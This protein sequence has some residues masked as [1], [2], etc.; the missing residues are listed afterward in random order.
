MET[1]METKR[2]KNSMMKK[3]TLAIAILA[4]SLTQ[5][6]NAESTQLETDNT[7][8]YWGVGIGS[9]IGAV[10]AGPPGAALGATLGGSIGW[11]QDKDQAL[12]Q[13]LVELEKNEQVLGQ[14]QAALHQKQTT[15]LQ[16]KQALSELSRAN[17]Q[18]S[19]QLVNLKMQETGDDAQTNKTLQEVIGHY[20]QEVYFRNGESGVPIYA[21][22]RLNRLTE[23]LNSH[24]NLQVLLK[25]YTDQNGTAEFNTALAQARVDG[26]KEALLAKGVDASRV[27]TKAIGE[28]DSLLDSLLLTNESLADSSGDISDSGVSINDSSASVH[29]S[30]DYVL[31]RR[32]SIEL[33]ISDQTMQPIASIDEVTL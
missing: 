27:S 18:Q 23:F 30:N 4:L 21:E 26:I 22:D 24:P 33:S 6:A 9:V 15:L 13:S 1:M 3:N 31:D 14:T 2:M 8:T 29:D 20:A 16:T 19:A 17:A 12:D 28:T 32:V 10:I 5:T 7:S 11:G 25:G